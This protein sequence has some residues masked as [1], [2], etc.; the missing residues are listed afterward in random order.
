MR[1]DFDVLDTH[2]QKQWELGTKILNKCRNC[3]TGEVSMALAT[4]LF[5]STFCMH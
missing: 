2:F 4:G 3:F 1:N 5:W